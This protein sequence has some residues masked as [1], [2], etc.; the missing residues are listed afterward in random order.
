M[1][2]SHPRA[3]RRFTVGLAVLCFVAAACSADDDDDGARQGPVTAAEDAVASASATTA[4]PTEHDP[5]ADIEAAFVA[6]WDAVVRAQRG[7]SDTPTELFEGVATDDAIQQNADVAARYKRQG[8]VRVGEPVLSDIEVR[9]DGRS[10]TVSACL[11]ESEWLAEVGGQ[12]L[13][14][15]EGQLEPHPVAYEVIKTAGSWLIGSPVEA[16]GTITC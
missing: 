15:Q 7:E 9:V 4:T 16:E 1:N 13:P 11:D 8:L 14:P 2:G 5:A 10:A 12:A 3:S 6:Y